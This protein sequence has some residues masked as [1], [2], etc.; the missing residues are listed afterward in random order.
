MAGPH[1]QPVQISVEK[2][3]GLCDSHLWVSA[4]SPLAWLWSQLFGQGDTGQKRVRTR[5]FLHLDV[6]LLPHLTNYNLQSWMA[7]ASLLFKWNS[8]LRQLQLS[9]PRQTQTYKGILE[10]SFQNNQF[11]YR[12]LLQKYHTMAAENGVCFFLPN[13]S[14][15]STWKLGGLTTSRITFDQW[16]KGIGRELAGKFLFWSLL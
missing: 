3:W 6:C 4:K 14:D 8:N 7:A 13:G 10:N 1:G 2:W 12:T 11:T 16:G 15:D 5:T 9:P